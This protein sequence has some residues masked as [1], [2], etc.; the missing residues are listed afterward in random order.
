MTPEPESCG[1]L[2]NVLAEAR[3]AA[4]RYR[5]LTGRPLGCTGEIGELEA[6]SILGLEL[7]KVR[8]EGYD[9]IR[10]NGGRLET[11]QIKT[12]CVLP[13]GNPSQR[14]GRFDCSKEWQ[15]V[16]LVLLD[17]NLEASRI[18]EAD[19]AAVVDAL[20]APGSRSRNERGQLGV[21]KFKSIGRL[22]WERV[23]S[24]ED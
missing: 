11:I 5:E 1:G 13:G 21:G 20:I 22:V 2:P 19:R 10:R 16:M 7:A 3:H 18:Y 8:Q 4:R 6:A 9:A 12:R 23:P 14:I 15:F 24:R 17:E